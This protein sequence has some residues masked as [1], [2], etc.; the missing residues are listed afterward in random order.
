MLANIHLSI[1]DL[2]MRVFS[3]RPFRFETDGADRFLENLQRLR[4]L[5]GGLAPEFAAR[6]KSFRAAESQYRAWAARPEANLFTN[7]FLAPG[8]DAAITVAQELER[9]G[10]YE[11]AFFVSNIF[12][13]RTPQNHSQKFCT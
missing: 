9:V 3:Q 4:T 10:R 7:M 12:G 6:I 11:D 5:A 2:P 1:L 13:E 8:V